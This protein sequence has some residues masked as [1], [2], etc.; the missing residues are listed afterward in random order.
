MVGTSGV[1]T[2]GSSPILSEA[3]LWLRVGWE[4]AVSLPFCPRGVSVVFCLWG[5]KTIIVVHDECH[6]CVCAVLFC[7]KL[8][9]LLDAA[10]LWNIDGY[11]IN[12][13]RF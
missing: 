8:C 12:E 10:F 11:S 2:S 9:V 13:W 4:T 1:P 5:E 6:V 7:L 3:P